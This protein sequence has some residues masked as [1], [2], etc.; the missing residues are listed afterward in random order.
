MY[1]KTATTA[2]I[3]ESFWIMNWIEYFIRCIYS[4]PRSDFKMISCSR[5]AIYGGCGRS[6]FAPGRNP[7]TWKYRRTIFFL[8]QEC[9]AEVV[10]SA[11]TKPIELWTRTIRRAEIEASG[12]SEKQFLDAVWLRSWSKKGLYR[13]MFNNFLHCFAYYVI[14]TVCC[15]CRVY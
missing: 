11:R 3:N 4:S 1:K 5:R 14:Q 2:P 8:F 7:S 15:V 12:N 13:K 9:S 6:R 10:F